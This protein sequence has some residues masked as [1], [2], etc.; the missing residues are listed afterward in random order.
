[1]MIC[2]PGVHEIIMM[3]TIRLR[4]CWLYLYDFEKV[5]SLANVV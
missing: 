2:R 3:M 4:D 1:M 5:K